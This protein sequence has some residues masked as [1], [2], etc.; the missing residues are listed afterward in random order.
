MAD[1]NL[2]GGSGTSERNSDLVKLYL[3]KHTTFAKVLS[4][5]SEKTNGGRAKNVLAFVSALRT[6]KL[7]HL[8]GWNVLLT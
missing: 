4:F 6:N 7:L 2:W 3:K 8:G 5:K 1:A